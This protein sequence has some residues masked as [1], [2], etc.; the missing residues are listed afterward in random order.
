MDSR[1]EA[2][3]AGLEKLA[4]GRLY[5]EL[6]KDCQVLAT[7]NDAPVW[8]A[9]TARGVIS[10]LDLLFA[11]AAG[12]TAAELRRYF[13]VARVVLGE[14]DPALDL[15]EDQ[16]WRASAEGKVREFSSAFRDGISETLV[17]LSVHGH[18]VFKGRLGI[19]IESEVNSVVR[20]LLRPR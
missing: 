2:D 20:D 8:S 10:K 1:N 7:L 19:D 12:V 9:G 16:R 15:D 3:K 13:E 4:G 14:D 18:E 11:V 17:L 6:E 5:D